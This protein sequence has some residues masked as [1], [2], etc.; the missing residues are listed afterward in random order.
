MRIVCDVGNTETTI[1]LLRDDTVAHRW[2]IT[3]ASGRTTDEWKVL[4]RGVMHD[5]P[6]GEVAVRGAAIG[7]VVPRSTTALRDALHSLFDLRPIEITAASPLGLRV[8]VDEPLAVGVDRLINTFAAVERHQRDCIVIDLGTA[9]TYDCVTTERVF[10]GGVIAPGVRTSLETLTARTAQLHLTPLAAPQRAIGRRTSECL[11]SGVVFGAA[12]ALE[13][14]VRRLRAE[15]P[16]SR[17]P[18]VVAT[19][20]LARLL[21]PVCPSIELVDPD[22]T[23]RGLALAHDRLATDAAD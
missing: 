4:L 6:A 11:Q 18:F 16:T 19:G 21:A 3:T 12:D 10:L 17:T 22:L 5:V 23:L 15:W 7:S 20:G 8:Q 1:A 9:T 2:R 14:M 13:G